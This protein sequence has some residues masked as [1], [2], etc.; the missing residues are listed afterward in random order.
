M[1]SV[2][3]L[4]PHRAPEPGEQG[5]MPIEARVSRVGGGGGDIASR[6]QCLF[7]KLIHFSPLGFFQQKDGHDN[8]THLLGLRGGRK[9]TRNIRPSNCVLAREAALLH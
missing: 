3:F 8:S 5:Y 2:T 1:A 7:D 6:P 4:W 9:G